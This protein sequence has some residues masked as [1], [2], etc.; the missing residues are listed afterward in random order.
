MATALTTMTLTELG[1]AFAAPARCDGKR[2]TIVGTKG[3]DSLLGTGGA[4]VI[5][6]KSG[7][8]F[9]QSRGGG[10]LV[11]AGRDFDVIRGGRGEDRVLGG[12]GDD[13]LV[14]NSGADQLRGQTGVDALF[15]DSGND[16]LFAGRGVGLGSEGLIGGAGD[17]VLNGGPGLDSAAFFNSPQGVQVDLDA[18]TASGHGTDQLVRVEGVGGS[19][20]DDTIAGDEGTNG[21]F[22]QE[23]NDTLIGR[24]SGTLESN[25]FDVLSGDGG[26]DDIQGGPGFDFVTFAREPLPATVDLEAETA[27]GNGN[28]TLDEIEGAFGSVEGD[29]LLGDA[30]DNA[31]VPGEGDDQVDG[32]DGEDTV[33]YRGGS[34]AV[35]VDLS[36]R[37]AAGAGMDELLAMENA[38]GSLGA[39]LLIGDAGPNELIGFNGKDGISGG[40][41]DDL[42]DGGEGVDNLDGGEDSDTCLNGEQTLDCESFTTTATTLSGMGFHSWLLLVEGRAS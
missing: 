3:A 42:L 6:T 8:D 28:D 24:D 9:I 21:L 37:E 5:V 41:G 18:G 26:D 32:R 36:A 40:A 7:D 12:R 11:C 4:D 33:I 17:D 27:T 14:G 35:V 34:G 25:L 20:F 16:R 15:G 22:G 31:F 23:G 2:A 10:D 29:V 19:N 13:T 1:P 38:W 39:D 30:T